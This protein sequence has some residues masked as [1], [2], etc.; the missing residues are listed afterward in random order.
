MMEF[1]LRK[2]GFY[3]IALGYPLFETGTG[4]LRI[5]ITANHTNEQIDGLVQAFKEVAEDTHYF[6]NMKRYEQVLKEDG[7]PIISDQEWWKKQPM[8]AKL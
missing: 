8:T 5:I 3:V 6:E 7:N 2:K 4:R 1:A